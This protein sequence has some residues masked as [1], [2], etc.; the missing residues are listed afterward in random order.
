M[1]DVD[2]M[3]NLFVSSMHQ[4][5]SDCVPTKEVNMRQDPKPFWFDKDCEKSTPKKGTCTLISKKRVTCST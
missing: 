5:I 2:E 3:W 4:A 1:D